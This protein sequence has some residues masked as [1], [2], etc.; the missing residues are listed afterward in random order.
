MTRI[1]SLLL[2]M[3]IAGVACRTPA[4]RREDFGNAVRMYNEGVRWQ[5]WSHAAAYIPGPERADF[6][7]ERAD[8]EEELRIDDFEVL[9]QDLQPGG[10]RAT[11]RVRYT[12]HLDR[13][14]IVHRTTATQGWEQRGRRWYM[15]EERRA[16]G[17]RMPG[18]AEP[19]QPLK[20]GDGT[21]DRVN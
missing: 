7:D 9:R 14:G 16:R 8:L 6:V 21:Q 11:V 18:V 12:W 3:S 10:Q 5:R 4:Q 13:E 17:P 20:V 1:A 19:L 2:L 15:V